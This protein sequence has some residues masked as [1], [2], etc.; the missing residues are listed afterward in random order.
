MKKQGL[1]REPSEAGRVGRSGAAERTSPAGHGRASDT[2]LVTRWYCC[3]QSVGPLV[4]ECRAQRPRFSSEDAP[5]ARRGKAEAKRHIRTAVNRSQADRLE[6]QMA[7]IG[8]NAMHYILTFSP[9]NLPKNFD[10]V[11]AA[12][13]SFMQAVRR[14]RQRQGKPK[15]FDYIP[16]IEGLHEPYHIHLICDAKELDP[17]DIQ[18]L[19]TFGMC[20]PPE[21]VL[22]DKS[23]FRRLAMYF[24]KERQDGY[25]IPVGKHPRTCSRSLR[26]KITEPER[27]MDDDGTI[28]PD[29]SAICFST[30]TGCAEVFSSG[31]GAFSK[32]SWLLPD[33]TQ[34]CRK[35]MKRMGYGGKNGT[36]SKKGLSRLPCLPPADAAADR[37]EYQ[38]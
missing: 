26:G 29:K 8:W 2:K 12:L 32:L 7:A 27:W 16:I 34:A 6:I 30:P 17:C 10:G 37:Q 13:H 35:A 33:S 1:P 9:E 22:A 25:M 31:W 15:S 38:G 5:T 14:E 20:K 11:R 28:T 19:W 4:K 18:R 36:E 23:G 3:R 24:T 21:W